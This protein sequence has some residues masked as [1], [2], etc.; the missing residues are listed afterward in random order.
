MMAKLIGIF[1]QDKWNFENRQL[2]LDIDENLTMV[3]Q[4]HDVCASFDQHPLKNKE[5][6][7]FDVK[8]SLLSKEEIVDALTVTGKELFNTL[9]QTVF[10]VGCRRS[11]ERLFNQLCESGYPAVQ[12]LVVTVDG[13]LTVN[14]N[15]L[16]ESRSLCE[17]FHSLG[18][19]LN[20]LIEA[21]PKNK[22]NRRCLLHSLESQRSKPVGNWLEIWDLM[23]KEC[24][25]QVV[26]VEPDVLL[27]TLES[28]LRKHRFCGEC[29]SKVMRAYNILIGKL[30]GT[31]EKGYASHLYKGIRCCP[32][33]KNIHVLGEANFISSLITRAEPEFRVNI[34]F[35]TRERH[36]KTVE[37]AQEEVLIC[38]GICLYERLHRIWQRLHEEEQT[39]QILFHLGVNELWKNFQLAIEAKQGFSQLELV[40]EELN[41]E[42]LLKQKR[43]ELKRLKK[44]KKK[45]L[46]KVRFWAKCEIENENCLNCSDKVEIDEKAIHCDCNELQY[47]F[48]ESAVPLVPLVP[49]ATIST[50]KLCSGQCTN[51]S[52]IG[53]GSGSGSGKRENCCLESGY[54]SA[55]NGNE[56]SSSSSSCENSEIASNELFHEQESDSQIGNQCSSA[57][58]QRCSTSF[59]CRCFPVNW[60]CNNA[61]AKCRMYAGSSL[62]DMLEGCS[63]DCEDTEEEISSEMKAKL[64]EMDKQRQELRQRLRERFAHLKGTL[65]C[66]P[67]TIKRTVSTELN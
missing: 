53:S 50:C 67:I 4:F 14:E 38:L 64:R 61:T 54:C 7:Q 65:L 41:R 6:M 32:S 43:L 25:E 59:V 62:Q 12:P 63:C 2:P 1:H 49:R 11:V 42:E 27:D 30:D 5:L 36:A 15:F 23:S 18:T 19:K 44:K 60:L 33:E 28:Y 24:R 20:S 56:S 39:W 57:T 35:S 22:K 26:L 34:S 10:C 31:K 21:I 37:N 13:I 40:C 9:A 52:W 16:T 66:T 51:S 8:F 48:D 55:S 17:I 58:C 45:I 3:M 29:K 46:T 47:E